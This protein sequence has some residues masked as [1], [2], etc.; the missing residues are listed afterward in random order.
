MPV[1]GWRLLGAG[2]VCRGHW[3]PAGG[4]GMSGDN[5]GEGGLG[6]W[7]HWTPVQGPNTPTWQGCRA[8]VG[9]RGVG[10]QGPEGVRGCQGALGTAGGVETSGGIRD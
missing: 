8:S 6:A 10:A 2:R 1:L 7:P 4:V 9:I 3:G 5:Q